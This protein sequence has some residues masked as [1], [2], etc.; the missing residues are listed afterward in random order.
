MPLGMKGTGGR[1]QTVGTTLQSYMS[2]QV[3]RGYVEQILSP[4]SESLLLLFLDK[5]KEQRRPHRPEG[6]NPETRQGFRGEP[7][8]D[9]ARV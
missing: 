8:L 5:H 4:S 7:L 2:K 9:R 1:V 6:A 3:R